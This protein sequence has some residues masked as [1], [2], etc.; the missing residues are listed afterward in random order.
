MPSTNAFLSSGYPPC[1]NEEADHLAKAGSKHPQPKYPVSYST[2]QNLIHSKARQTWQQRWDSG[3]TARSLHDNK[4]S[5]TKSDPIYTLG[6]HK[7]TTIFKLRTGHVQLN[8]HLNRIDAKSS[9]NCPHCPD[10][11][12]SVQ[13]FIQDC[14]HYSTH[15]RKIWTTIAN[16]H[17][18]LFGERQH[19]E[20]T[21][22]YMTATG[23]MRSHSSQRER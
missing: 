5:P 20:E 22:R 18:M 4:P 10:L 23:R 16:T 6:S 9:Q 1:G 3:L 21:M 15:R 14:P 12:E 2:V 17:T 19:L 13:Y 8:Q 7:Q 11:E